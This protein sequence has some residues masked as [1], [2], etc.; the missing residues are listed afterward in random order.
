MLSQ[1]YLKTSALKLSKKIIN[2]KINKSFFKK[3]FKHLVIDDFL[4]KEFANLCLKNFPNIKNKD[5]WAKSNIK[6]IEVK[7]RS[8]WESEFDIPN[9]I[10]E[11]VRVLNSALI[12]KS[13]SAKFS[14]P[15]LMPDPYFTGGGLN[16]TEKGGL[17]DVHVDGNYHDASSLNRRINII[18]YFNKKWKSNWG[19]ELGLYS[20]NGKKCLKKV[21]PLFNRIIIFDTHDFSFH[22]LPNPLNF[23]KEQNR[24]SLILYYYTKHSRPKHQTKISKPHSALWVKKKLLDKNGKI[25]RKYY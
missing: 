9:G 19:G 24:K 5:K 22:G 3:P 12:L 17:L 18:I 23:P 8:N 11:L 13:V 4:D 10:V 16:V 21:E 1:K 2:C 7:Y 15:K 14:V 20:S 6:N 25:V